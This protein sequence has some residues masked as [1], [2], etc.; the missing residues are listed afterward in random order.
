MS[1]WEV[2]VKFPRIKGFSWWV[3]SD[4]YETLEEG[5]RAGMESEHPGGCRQELPLLAAEV[6]EALLLFPDPTE[7][8]SSLRP[9][10]PWASVSILRQILQLVNRHASEQH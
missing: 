1:S 3:E 5:L 6:Q 8:E 2:E 9:V 7:L 4:E 10:V